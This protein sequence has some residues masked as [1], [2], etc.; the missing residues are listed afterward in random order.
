MKLREGKPSRILFSKPVKSKV[1]VI[2]TTRNKYDLHA[3]NLFYTG[4]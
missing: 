3:K 4:Q 2:F 1:F